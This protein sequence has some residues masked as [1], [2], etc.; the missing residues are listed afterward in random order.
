[1]RMHHV[2]LIEDEV[3]IA[4]AISFILRRDGLQVTVFADGAGAVAAVHAARPDMLIL[5][6]MLP[7][8]SGLEIVAALRADAALCD[9][10]VLMLTAKGHGRD[11]DAALQA[12]V[13]RF[14]TKPFA[15]AEMLAAVRA[16]LP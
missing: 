1:M 4:E 3:H 8:A 13:T 16:L 15:N 5:D 2:M 12:G 7:G 6:L 14:M 9:L 10:P 11:R